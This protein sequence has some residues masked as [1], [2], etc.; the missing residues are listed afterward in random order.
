MP[1]ILSVGQCGFDGPRIASLLKNSLGAEVDSAG[2]YSEAEAALNQKQYDLVLVNRILFDDGTSG[3]ELIKR[4]QGSSSAP[5]TMLV[6]NYP[7]AQAEAVAIGSQ[8]GFGKD[9]L[10]KPETL[11]LLKNALAK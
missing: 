9:A 10:G 4:I 1:N 2:T 7:E 5:K 3:L 8:Q 11:S 6:S